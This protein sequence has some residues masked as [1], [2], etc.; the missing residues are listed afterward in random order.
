MFGHWNQ[1]FENSY[2]AFDCMSLKSLEGCDNLTAL[3]DLTPLISS[4][5]W[6]D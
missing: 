4:G 3:C 5:E 1:D 2:I 6:M